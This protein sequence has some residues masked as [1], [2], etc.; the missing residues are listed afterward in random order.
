MFIKFQSN[1]TNTLLIHSFNKFKIWH[2][3]VRPDRIH[4]FCGYDGR[5]AVSRVKKRKK[6]RETK[7]SSARVEWC[8]MTGSGL[9]SFSLFSVQNVCNIECGRPVS[10]VPF[11]L[12]RLPRNRVHVFP[13]VVLCFAVIYIPSFFILLYNQE[14]RG[15]ERDSWRTNN[16]R[17]AG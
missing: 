13:W 4:W 16:G 8:H 2:L 5:G 12:D 15:R 6:K 14:K 10:F 3:F 17:L 9:L 11:S 7:W 1:F